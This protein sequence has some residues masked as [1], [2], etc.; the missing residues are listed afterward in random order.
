[1][2]AVAGGPEKAAFCASIG[3]D[4]VIDRKKQ[5]V[6]TTARELTDGKGV[7]LVFDPV[8]GKAGRDARRLYAAASS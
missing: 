1:M 6:K 5:D 2:I 3:A 4:A 7:S 8:G